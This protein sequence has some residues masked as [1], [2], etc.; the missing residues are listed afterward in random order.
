MNNLS[1]NGFFLGANT[2]AGFLSLYGSELSGYDRKYIL[3]GSPGC[4]K[5]TFMLRCAKVLEEKGAQV[6]YI[7]CSS[8]PDSLD[9]V[10]IPSLGTAIV[11]GTFP[12]VAE[13]DY[14]LAG[15]YYVDFGAFCDIAA[16]RGIKEEIRAI[17]DEYH[18]VYG[19]IY[20][21]LRAAGA[22]HKERVNTVRSI[23]RGLEFRAGGLIK[24]L[25]GK[26]NGDTQG[27]E[28]LRFLSTICSRGI[29]HQYEAARALCSKIYE[30]RTDHDLGGDLIA[31][32]RGA[33][34]DA[35]HD[36]ISCPS[37]WDPGGQ[38]MHLLIPSL[39]LGFL[40]TGKTDPPEK[41]SFRR[42]LTDRTVDGSELSRQR[43][44]LR[45][46][47]QSEN[48]VVL[49][50]VDILAQAKNIHDRLEALYNPHIDFGRVLQSAERLA[51]ELARGL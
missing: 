18:A 40:M 34:L 7:L 41:G 24:K 28:R 31:A 36:V 6:E 45:S 46:L 51:G 42:I 27:K 15:E 16:L 37:P 20:G 35:G 21:L 25:I 1:L 8:D 50:A 33:A 10:L 22:L 2:P 11:D 5:S 38:P 39:D 19:R 13:P 17:T 9:G 32:I 3:K 47:R 14:P 43:P 26:K 44:Y 48:A 29:I 30:I 4:G 12:H 49:L 23:S